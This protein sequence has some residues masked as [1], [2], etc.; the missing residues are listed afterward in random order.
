MSKLILGLV[1]GFLAI[2]KIRG[3]PSL[4]IARDL[5]LVLGGV[6]LFLLILSLIVG[7]IGG[8]FLAGRK[9]LS[10]LK[11][12][13]KDRVMIISPHPD[14]ETLAT[15]GLI[16]DLCSRRI[17]LKIVILTSGDGNP[18]LFL[19]DRK[20][21]FSPAKFIA[22]GKER[23]KE[24]V[25]AIKILG[26][27]KSKVV[28]LGYPDGCLWKMCQN[29][30]EVVASKTT[31][32]THSPYQSTFK[33][34]QEYKGENVIKDLKELIKQFKPT[35]IFVSH[36]KE[37]NPDHRAT[38]FLTTQALKQAKWKGKVYQYL[39]HFVWLKLFRLYPP[40]TT[41]GEK[42]KILYPPYPLWKKGRC[43][44]FWLRPEQLRRKKAALKAYQSQLI[45]PTL[46][47]LFASFLTQNE[48]FC[49]AD[50]SSSSSK[51]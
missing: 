45:L 40:K 4:L 51:R 30:Q 32:L 21:K 3:V 11:I 33:K 16:A 17:P 39:I 44:S 1:S 22:T 7:I 25:K 23:Q 8:W 15:G 38:F 20:I 34:N 12:K 18:S 46:R 47:H 43:F 14:D 27:N 36:Q 35:V 29:P 10:L 41:K 6:V 19:R 37:S 13:K 48:I 2:E 5:A 42:E 28:F 49:L 24:T 50:Y 9:A 31:E 26:G